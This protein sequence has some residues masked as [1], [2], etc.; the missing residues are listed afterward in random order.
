MAQEVSVREQAERQAGVDSGIGRVR[1][2]GLM[3]TPVAAAPPDQP[4][5]AHA[6]SS[7][8]VQRRAQAVEDVGPAQG[9][10][11]DHGPLLQLWQRLERVGD[12]A[13][14]I[15]VGVEE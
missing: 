6:E 15:W 9:R 12:V 7:Q 8:A 14:I 11:A 13:F 5:G 4:A 3:A 10:G 2:E 1:S